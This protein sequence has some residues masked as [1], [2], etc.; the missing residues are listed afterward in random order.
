L[1]LELINER[2]DRAL[3]DNRR[4][5][6]IVI[7]MASCIFVMG[8]CVLLLSYWFKNVYVAGGSALFQG[9]L[10]WPIQGSVEAAA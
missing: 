7:I 9:L 6:Y 1:N 8:A 10:Y 4:A 3:S 2:V 5:E